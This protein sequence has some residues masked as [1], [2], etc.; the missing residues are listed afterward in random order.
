MTSLAQQNLG[1]LI[2]SCF[3]SILTYPFP[4]SSL[5]L[6]SAMSATG[7]DPSNKMSSGSD[8]EAEKVFTT[9]D[10]ASHHSLQR[11]LKNRHIAMIR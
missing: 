11:Q 6:S 7:D 1:S 8:V 2:K 10:D 5:L 4:P 9:S 3:D